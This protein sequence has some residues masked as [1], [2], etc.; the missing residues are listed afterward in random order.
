MNTVMIFT[1][2]FAA[3][4]FGFIIGLLTNGGNFRKDEV[5]TASRAT[6]E[7]FEQSEE[8]RN[9]LNYDGSEQV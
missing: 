6:S 3:F 7:C 1:S 4:S 2:A 8:Y 5:K 9:F